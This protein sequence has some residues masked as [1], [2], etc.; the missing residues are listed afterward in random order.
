MRIL[1]QSGLTWRTRSSGLPRASTAA[2]RLG[3][4]TSERQFL[5]IVQTRT[6]VALGRPTRLTH[7]VLAARR[8]ANCSDQLG[9]RGRRGTSLEGA[10]IS[11]RER[12][13]SGK[14]SGCR[15]SLRL[16]GSG[17]VRGVP[18]S[19]YTSSHLISIPTPTQLLRACRQQ[20][21][22]CGGS[23]GMSALSCQA[24][25]DDPVEPQA[26]RSE[27]TVSLITTKWLFQCPSVARCIL[28][29]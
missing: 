10:A 20:Q 8:R 29:E 12:K 11:K 22:N 24:L 21:R 13:G 2:G 14:G 27:S 15:G 5:K 1:S 3:Q 7:M 19:Q 17:W 26:K 28:F 9:S 18:V 6:L 4:P 23:C 25:P 16:G